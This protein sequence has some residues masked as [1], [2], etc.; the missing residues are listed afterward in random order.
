MRGG[1]QR[2]FGIFPKIHPI[3]LPDSSLRNHGAFLFWSAYISGK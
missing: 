2:R 3:W 1:G